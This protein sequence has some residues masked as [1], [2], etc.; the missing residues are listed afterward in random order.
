MLPASLRST[1]CTLKIDARSFDD[2]ANTPSAHFVNL[3]GA[4][5]RLSA[6]ANLSVNICFPLVLSDADVCAMATAFP[7]L[8]VLELQW[9]LQSNDGMPSVFSLG[10]FARKCPRLRELAIPCLACRCSSSRASG[11]VRMQLQ[12]VPAHGLEY[13]TF[14]YD[15]PRDP[16]PVGVLNALRAANFIYRTFPD[17]EVDF[18][19]DNPTCERVVAPIAHYFHRMVEVLARARQRIHDGL[20]NAPPVTAS[21][22][23]PLPVVAHRSMSV[24]YYRQSL[25]SVRT[26]YYVLFNIVRMVGSGRG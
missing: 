17:A 15:M 3:L 11:D 16:T 19:C 10:H 21:D 8:E 12:D 14:E 5:L 13:L 25:V 18:D 24:H 2:R 4:I 7:R 26:V 22:S 1:L 23:L 9:P 6:L 20:E